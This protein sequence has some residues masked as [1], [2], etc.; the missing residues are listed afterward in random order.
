MTGNK[1]GAREDCWREDA[2]RRFEQTGCSVCGE[3]ANRTMGFRRSSRG[4][5]ELACV[6][7]CNSSRFDVL[8]EP[9]EHTRAPRRR[10]RPYRLSPSAFLLFA[11][12]AAS[13][14]ARSNTEL[15]LH[16]NQTLR[17]LGRVPLSE[18]TVRTYLRGLGAPREADAGRRQRPVH[19]VGGLPPERRD[20]GRVV[21]RGDRDPGMAEPFADDGQRDS[22]G[23]HQGRGAVA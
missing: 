9:V 19:G 2:I 1:S 17:R 6:P 13:N 21:G 3:R 4:G 10:G 23:E 20:D 11:L 8:T 16:I 12:E 7:D 14:G 18:R 5:Y 15:R 22:L